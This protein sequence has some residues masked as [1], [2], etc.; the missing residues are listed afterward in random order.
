MERVPVVLLLDACVLVL[1]VHRGAESDGERVGALAE[2]SGGE[3][4][5]G[6]G[7]LDG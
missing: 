5:W 3:G 2:A 1:P 4:C 7:L 6:A